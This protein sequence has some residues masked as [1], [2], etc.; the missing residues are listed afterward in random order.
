MGCPGTLGN[1]EIGQL[2]CED[3]SRRRVVAEVLLVPELEVRCTG[4][5]ADP[6]LTKQP[7]VEV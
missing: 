7:K 4:A 5:G 2:V 3:G 1:W 6:R